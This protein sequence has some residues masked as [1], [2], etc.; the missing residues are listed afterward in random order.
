MAARPLV[1]PYVKTNTDNSLAG[2]PWSSAFTLDIRNG[3]ISP[4]EE[5]EEAK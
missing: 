2:R 5:L 3:V 4:L 1:F